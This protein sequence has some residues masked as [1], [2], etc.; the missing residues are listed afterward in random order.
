MLI[1]SGKRRKSSAGADLSESLVF[2]AK[3]PM[4][5]G[6]EQRQRAVAVAFGNEGADQRFGTCHV[7]PAG[8][9]AFGGL[10]AFGNLEWS[11]AVH[12]RSPHERA[13]R[14]CPDCHSRI[15]GDALYFRR[16]SR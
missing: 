15:C 2:L 8:F 12:M 10:L 13:S 14:W 16:S 6:P 9:E 5:L 3:R 1:I 11:L 4:D 7:L